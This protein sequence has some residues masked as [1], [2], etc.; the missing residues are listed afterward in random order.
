MTARSERVFLL[1]LMFFCDRE[2]IN[3]EYDTPNS[4]Q[5]ALIREIQS[6]LKDLFLFFLSLKAYCKDLILDCFAVLYNLLLAP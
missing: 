1:S 3:L 5:P 4:L 2:L 6:D